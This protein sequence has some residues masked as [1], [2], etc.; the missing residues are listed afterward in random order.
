MKTLFASI[1]F[2]LCIFATKAQTGD[3]SG[4]I[5]NQYGEGL[6]FARAMEVDSQGIETE[7]GVKADAKGNYSIRLLA[8]GKYNVQYSAKG[9]VSQIQKGIIVSADKSTFMDI[10]LKPDT[11]KLK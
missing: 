7:K 6:R 10:Q 1:I 4:K 11:R 9:Y 3:I 8:P 2:M 5:T